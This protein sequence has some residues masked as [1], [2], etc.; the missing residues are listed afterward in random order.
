MLLTGCGAGHP[1]NPV[2]TGPFGGKNFASPSRREGVRGGEPI[3]RFGRT[4]R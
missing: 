2:N 4:R 1:V 3:I